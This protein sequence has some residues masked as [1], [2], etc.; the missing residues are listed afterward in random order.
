MKQITQEKCP[1]TYVSQLFMDQAVDLF[2]MIHQGKGIRHPEVLNE[3]EHEKILAKL[4]DCKASNAGK[5]LPM[6]GSDSVDG[7]GPFEEVKTSIFSHHM[8]STLVSK[9]FF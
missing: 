5:H 1:P 3:N 4:N 2:I 8:I 9:L 7:C 6:Y